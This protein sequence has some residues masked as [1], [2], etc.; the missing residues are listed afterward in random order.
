MSASLAW[1][2]QDRGL[3]VLLVTKIQLSTSRTEE[4]PGAAANFP[5][6][7]ASSGKSSLSTPPH[8]FIKH[9]SDLTPRSTGMG[10]LQKLEA[11]SQTSLCF[12]PTVT[13][14]KTLCHSAPQFPHLTLG[15]FPWAM[16]LTVQSYV[17]QHEQHLG[18]CGRCNLWGFTPEPLNWKPRGRIHSLCLLK[19]A[20]V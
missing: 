5:S 14:D 15:G 2:F 1:I 3:C 7:P 19:L 13:L 12:R 17:H 9:F 10:S 4:I 6:Q 20:Q 11:G 18:T 8:S 16:V